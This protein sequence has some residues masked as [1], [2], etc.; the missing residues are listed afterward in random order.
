MH[1]GIA[2]P[3]GLFFVFGK[4]RCIFQVLF[5]AACWGAHAR[6]AD[7][8][9]T[10]HTHCRTHVANIITYMSHAHHTHITHI[11]TNVSHACHSHCCMHFHMHVTHL[12]HAMSH[13]C[14]MPSNYPQPVPRSIPLLSTSPITARRS[15]SPPPAPTGGGRCSPASPSRGWSWRPCWRPSPP[16]TPLHWW[17]A[18]ASWPSGPPGPHAPAMRCHAVPWRRFLEA[19]VSP[20]ITQHK[21]PAYAPDLLLYTFLPHSLPAV[22]QLFL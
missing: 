20:I 9:Y 2:F 13:T 5:F 4:A 17:P 22:I 19:D 15:A 1:L 3:V 8:S 16:P 11:G 12:S 21:H 18:C 6:F 7:I 10:Y 14:H